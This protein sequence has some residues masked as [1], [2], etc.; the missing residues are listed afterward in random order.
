MVKRKAKDG[1]D[2]HAE[3]PR[4]SS[5]RILTPKEDVTIPK[6]SAGATKTGKTAQKASKKDK[7][8][9]GVKTEVTEPVCATSLLRIHTWKQQ[10][11]CRVPEK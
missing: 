7:Q 9:K 5:R 8:V 3:E 1:A 2:E 6:T 11:A 4:R 10:S